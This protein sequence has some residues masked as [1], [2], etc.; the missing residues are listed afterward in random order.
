[1]RCLFSSLLLAVFWPDPRNPLPD[2][3]HSYSI[4]PHTNP[5]TT[6]IL[7][8]VIKLSPMRPRERPHTGLCGARE[9][10]YGAMSE[11][12]ATTWKG[13]LRVEFVGHRARPP[14]FC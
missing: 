2:R 6:N 12:P 4:V 13:R 8:S 10:A 5:L 1:M 3:P 11:M 7:F 9:D 14:Y